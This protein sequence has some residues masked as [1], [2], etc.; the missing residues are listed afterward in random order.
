[1][2]DLTDDEL[3]AD[4][5]AM[6]KEAV[7]AMI[8]RQLET[9]AMCAK[10][11]LRPSTVRWVNRTKPSYAAPLDTPP[12]EPE[13]LIVEELMHETGAH[14]A[15]TTICLMPDLYLRLTVDVD[16]DLIECSREADEVPS[17]RPVRNG[18]LN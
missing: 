2:S 10:A 15:T 13:V 6:S 14:L 8:Q 4:A 18:S 3:R 5:Q 17:P 12:L 7:H 16:K 11:G 9:L 1:V